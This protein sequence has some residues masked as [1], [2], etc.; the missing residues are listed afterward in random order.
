MLTIGFVTNRTV[1]LGLGN[2][3]LILLLLS[4]AVCVVTFSSA[5]T[6]VLQGAVHLLLFAAY[7]MTIFD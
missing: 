1:E 5:R 3:D 6:Y 4:L 2:V 7:V